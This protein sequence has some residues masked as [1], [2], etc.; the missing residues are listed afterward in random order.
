MSL[1]SPTLTRSSGAAWFILCAI[2]L[3]HMLNDVMQ[4]MLQ[5]IYPLLQAEFSLSYSQIGL[6]SFAFQVTASLLQPAIGGFTDRHPMPRSLPWG[7]GSSLIG[8]VLLAT[9]PGYPL[10]FLGAIVAM[11]IIWAVVFHLARRVTLRRAAS[12]PRNSRRPDTNTSRNKIT[13]AGRISHGFIP[14]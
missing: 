10:L 4:S 14:E 13:V 5:A 2:S 11:A 7:M 8:V 6:L 1:A 12:A 3:C 9:A